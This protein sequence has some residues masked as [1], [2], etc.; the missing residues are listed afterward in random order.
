MCERSAQ[1]ALL[2]Y[3]IGKYML[4]YSDKV[5]YTFPPYRKRVF[6]IVEKNMGGITKTPSKLLKEEKY[7][8]V[9]KDGKTRLPSSG[10]VFAFRDWTCHVTTCASFF[11]NGGILALF[12]PRY[13]GEAGSFGKG[14]GKDNGRSMLFRE[15]N[16]ANRAVEK[17]GS[18]DYDTK[19]FRIPLSSARDSRSA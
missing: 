16:G 8:G 9:R 2:F 14:C 6:L 3:G 13:A 12:M 15:G 7:G 10:L 19:S 17:T 1:A 4:L 11:A 18:R 5:T